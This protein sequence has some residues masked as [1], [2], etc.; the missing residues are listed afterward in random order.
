MRPKGFLCIICQQ[1]KPMKEFGAGYLGNR[2]APL[3][4]DVLNDGWCRACVAAENKR[5]RAQDY[6]GN[7]QYDRP[8]KYVI[9]P[10]EWA[11]FGY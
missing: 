6:L 11:R 9:N 2:V 1:K 3:P 7:C 10:D 4:P 8:P 5:S